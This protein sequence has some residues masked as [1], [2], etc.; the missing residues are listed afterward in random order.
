MLCA[1]QSLTDISVS[2][3]QDMLS[4]LK[5]EGPTT[6]GVFL[7][8]PSITLCQTIK[9]KL[10]SEEEVDMNKQSVHVVSWIFKVGKVPPSSTLRVPES[11]ELVLFSLYSLE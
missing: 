9:D 6:E 7:V 5:R 3:S 10:D 11:M 8:R 1:A 2:T 4:L